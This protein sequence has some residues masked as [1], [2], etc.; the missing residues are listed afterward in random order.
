MFYKI[1]FNNVKKSIKD[2][3][4]YFLTLLFGVCLFY[5]FNAM[6]SQQAMDSFSQTQQMMLQAM[7]EIFGFISVFI[8]IVLAFLILY[9]NTFLIKRRKKELGLYLLLG[10]KKGKVSRML[11]LETLIIGIFALGAGLLIGIFASQGI[12]LLTAKMFQVQLKQFQF[13]FSKGACIKSILYFGFI[14]F[15]VMIFNVVLVGK[16]RLIDLLRGSKKGEKI[17]IHHLFVNAAVFIISIGCLIYAY[18]LIHENALSSMDWRLKTSLIL[19]VVGTFL[20]FLSLSGFVL[21][22]L[23]SWKKFYYSGL[24]MFVLRQLSSKITTTFISLSLIC[25]ML[26]ISITTLACGFAL[27]DLLMK[28]MVNSFPYDA[29]LYSYEGQKIDLDPSLVKDSYS[30]RLYKIESLTA[31]QLMKDMDQNVDSYISEQLKQQNVEAISLSD[32]NALA[33]SQGKETI[34]LKADEYAV[35]SDY[36]KVI[37][38]LNRFVEQSTADLPFEDSTLHA[39]YHEVIQMPLYNEG[40][41]LNLCTLVLPDELCGKLETSVCFTNI[42]YPQPNHTYEDPWI[43]YMKNHPTI[44]GS[45]RITTLE[46]AGGLQVICSYISLYIGIV[47]IITA[48]AVLA[49]QQLSESSD[50]IQRYI[51][52]RKLGAKESQISKAL[53]M[54]I[55][56]CFFAP[57]ALALVHSYVA[58]HIVNQKILEVTASDTWG[59]IL[60]TAGVLLIVYGGYFL[61]TYLSAKAMIKEKR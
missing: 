61:A 47:F 38:S 54:Q 46:M 42:N 14:F 51:L 20:F 10:A 59:S 27:S 4:V 23:R 55:A 34:S 17:R 36:D 58:I 29:T 57:L 33:K 12:S 40:L 41:G 28:E 18:Y 43:E 19:G 53:F 52:L 11:L 35:L 56:A 6:N 9:A 49:L 39:A 22:L 16:Y 30:C 2:Y 48:A 37:P 24:N 13:V 45:T 15:V 21:R 26:F 60:T 32:Y 25:L 50:N 8:S 5:V 7:N 3:T 1:A 44:Y 31:D